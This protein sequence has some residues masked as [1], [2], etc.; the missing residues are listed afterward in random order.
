MYVC[1]CY[2]HSQTHACFVL[3]GHVLLCASPD[4]L[5]GPLVL[6]LELELGLAIDSHSAYAHTHIYTYRYTHI[7]TDTYT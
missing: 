7:S 5:A 3:G 4:R 6:V 2:P 1:A